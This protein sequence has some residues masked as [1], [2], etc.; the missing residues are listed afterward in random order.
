M[1]PFTH[2]LLVMDAALLELSPVFSER[3]DFEKMR[4]SAA[5]H[6]TPLNLHFS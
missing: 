2:Q 5:K 4:K 1:V 3:E 6:K